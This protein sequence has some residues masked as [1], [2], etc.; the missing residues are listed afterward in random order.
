MSDNTKTDKPVTGNHFVLPFFK[1]PLTHPSSAPIATYLAEYLEHL[2]PAL[3]SLDEIISNTRAAQTNH[4]LQLNE[5]TDQ[6]TKLTNKQELDHNDIVDA[7]TTS[8]KNIEIDIARITTGFANELVDLKEQLTADFL[9][10]Q[11]EAT[12]AAAPVAESPDIPPPNTNDI[13][14]PTP[15]TTQLDLLHQ[16]QTKL[17]L[18]SYQI[19]NITESMIS[20]EQKI[21]TYRP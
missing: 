6:L 2:A 4:T 8:I 17:N 14:P 10:Q 20:L 15:S 12:A 3:I 9:S 13:S 16:L 5:R 7:H 21:S 18:I 19:T 11:N 1:P